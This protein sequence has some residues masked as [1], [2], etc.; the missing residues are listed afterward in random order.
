MADRKDPPPR[1]E[2][3]PGFGKVNVPWTESQRAGPTDPAE[4]ALLLLKQHARRWEEERAKN[5]ARHDA[6]D[7]ELDRVAVRLSK[8]ESAVNE[9]KA[10]AIEQGRTSLAVE[11]LASQMGLL[12]EHVMQS[13]QNH[14]NNADRDLVT[15]QQVNDLRLE[16]IS[17]AEREGQHAGATAGGKRGTIGGGIVAVLAMALYWFAEWG[18]HALAASGH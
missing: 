13:L 11:R 2:S 3:R 12:N 5:E 16:M 10:L 1:K 7:E 15:T 17:K 4:A 14:V 18:W 9:L 8:T 6:H